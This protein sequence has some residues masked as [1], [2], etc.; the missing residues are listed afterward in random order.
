[1]APRPNTRSNI[2][3]AK[4]QVF[5]RTARKVFRFLTVCKLFITMKIRENTI[6]DQIQYILSYIQRRSADVWKENIL[7]DLEAGVL[8]YEMV[9]EFLANLKKE[10]GG[11]DKE[12]VKV[13]KLK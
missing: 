12:T 3:V 11:G 6:K 5:D 1:M 9:G 8:E 10:F 2:E 4:P 13:T 7:E